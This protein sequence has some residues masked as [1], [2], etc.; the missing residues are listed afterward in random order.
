LV[1]KAADNNRVSVLDSNTAEAA[2]NNSVV[3]NNMAASKA[4]PL[5]RR[6]NRQRQMP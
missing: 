4:E 3:G 1:R 5:R 6:M 2:S